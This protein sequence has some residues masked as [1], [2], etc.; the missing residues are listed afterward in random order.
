MAAGSG[1]G[2][3]NRERM[4]QRAPIERSGKPG[5][6]PR[7]ALDILD[8]RTATPG[9]CAKTV[10]SLVWHTRLPMRVAEKIQI[11]IMKLP[12]R[13]IL[14]ARCGVGFPIT[15]EEMR[16]HLNYFNIST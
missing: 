15:K 14:S 10:V 5:L 11:F 4:D 1:G 7:D 8:I 12:T 16:W 9:A 2:Q 6:K 13:D 3:E